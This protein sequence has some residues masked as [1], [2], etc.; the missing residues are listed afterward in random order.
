[1]SADMMVGALDIVDLN[2]IDP[3]SIVAQHGPFVMLAN[4]IFLTSEPTEEQ[5]RDA[6]VWAQRVEKASPFWVADL[7]AYGEQKHEWGETYSQAI[8]ATGKAAGTLMN[9]VYV[10]KAVPPDR[11]LPGSTMSH[12]QEV[13]SLEPAEQ[14]AWLQK[15]A[16]EDLSAK[17]LRQAIKVS[18]AQA[19]GQ[20]L[21]FSIIVECT[22]EADQQ[23]LLNELKEKGRTCHAQTKAIT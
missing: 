4:S 10:A 9:Q 7:I 21:A 2:D 11:R 14:V 15:A 6:T 16:D 20:T 18:K 22:N 17:E 3:E 19:A 8:E 12:C 5:W 1:M 13:A 23:A